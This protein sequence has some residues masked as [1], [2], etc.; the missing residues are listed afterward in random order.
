LPLDKDWDPS[1]VQYNAI[2]KPSMPPY[3]F[4]S[5]FYDGVRQEINTFGGE[6]SYLSSNSADL[7]KYE[8]VLDG[9][10]GSAD[11]SIWKLALDGKGGGTW[12]Q[13]DTSKDPP[14][15]AGI[16]RPL[17]G[18]SAMNNETAFYLGGYSSS[19]SSPAT[20]NLTSFVPTPGLVEFDTKTREWTNNTDTRSLS[21]SGTFMW[22]AMESIPFGPNGLMVVF[23]GETSSRTE[24]V[25]VSRHR[26]RCDRLS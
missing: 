12:T 26:K 21:P 25:P 20:R 7:S 19:H 1:F 11:L 2:V 14:F 16:T 18:V 15:S 24:Y 9:T 10:G 6:L 17:G 22:G 13:N 4:Q 23:G 3:N 5:L 8:L